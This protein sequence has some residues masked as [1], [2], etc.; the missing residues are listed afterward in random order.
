MS[1]IESYYAQGLGIKRIGQLTRKSPTS[2]K[3]YLQRKGLYQGSEHKA[4]ELE[5]IVDLRDLATWQGKAAECVQVLDGQGWTVT[6]R[7]S[8]AELYCPLSMQY[9]GK[10]VRF[11]VLVNPQRQLDSIVLGFHRESQRQQVTVPS[12]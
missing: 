10:R 5:T 12:V 11:A 9:V 2:V 4:V 1:E 3:R 8:N 7:T 6:F